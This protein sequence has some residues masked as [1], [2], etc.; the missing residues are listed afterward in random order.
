MKLHDK[1]LTLLLE[2]ASFA[3]VDGKLHEREFQF[4]S[5]VAS[6]LKIPQEMFHNLLSLKINPAPI[7]SETIRIEHFYRLALLMFC[8]GV[9]DKREEIAIREIG[10]NMGLDPFAI[11]RIL[12]EM[13]QSPSRIIDPKRLMAIFMEQKN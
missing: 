5:L 8:D 4:L 2:M 1:K 9:I 7:K 10:V 13:E 11:N 3:L 6:E 12:K